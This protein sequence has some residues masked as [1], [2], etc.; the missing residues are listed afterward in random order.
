MVRKAFSPSYRGSTCLTSSEER[1][2]RN[3]RLVK[4]LAGCAPPHW[5]PV[6][7]V[8]RYPAIA[9]SLKHG[10]KKHRDCVVGLLL[11]DDTTRRPT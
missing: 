11:V 9:R 2:S 7:A 6:I 3:E 5:Q 1:G 8:N 4:Y 10:S